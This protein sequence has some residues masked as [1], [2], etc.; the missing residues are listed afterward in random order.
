MANIE[1]LRARTSCS[2]ISFEI[3][4]IGI[5]KT[6]QTDGT[7]DFALD[8]GYGGLNS[9][10]PRSCVFGQQIFC[11]DPQEDQERSENGDDEE[12]EDASTY[13]HN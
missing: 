12:E 8:L 4:T 5:T 6:A 9:N 10:V 13:L 3:R 7:G 2:Y 1:S 11:S